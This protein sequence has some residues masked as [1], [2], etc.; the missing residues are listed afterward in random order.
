MK[1]LPFEFAGRRW[2][3]GR[4]TLIMGILNV[5]PDSFSDGGLF[6]DTKAAVEHGQRMARAGAHL[7]DVGGEST[8]PG[9]PAVPA[10]EEIRRVVPV[11][12]ELSS[13]IGVPISIDTWKAEVAR[14]ALAAGALIVNDVSGLRRDPGMIDVLRQSAAGAV[15]MHMR[16]TPSTMQTLTRY[17]DLIGEVSEYFRGIIDAAAAAGVSRE[18]ILIDPGIGF[19]KTAEQ[20][21]HLIAQLDHF[22][23]RLDRPVLAGPSRKS[24]IGALLPGRSPPERVWGTAGAVACCVLAGADIVRVHDV[25]Q[26]RQVV[27]VVMAIRQVRELLAAAS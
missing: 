2:L 17:E 27:T 25:D 24:F 8:R 13:S 26:M 18:R 9:A 10:E 3:L 11:V 12:R 14:A 15:L 6:A 23:R 5:T 1:E 19:A 21:L 7:I 16:G 22:R 20:N 4:E